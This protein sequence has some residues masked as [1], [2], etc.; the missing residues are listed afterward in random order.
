MRMTVP[1]QVT[2][3]KLTV[4]IHFG[5]L[6][7]YLYWASQKKTDSLFNLFQ[8]LN[9]GL[10]LSETFSF[11]C[12][13]KAINIQ[14]TEVQRTYTNTLEALVARLFYNPGMFINAPHRLMLTVASHA[15]SPSHATTP[16]HC[17]YYQRTDMLSADR[18][19][20]CVLRYYLQTASAAF[21]A[22]TIV[23]QTYTSAD[24]SPAGGSGIVILRHLTALGGT[25]SLAHQKATC[26]NYLSVQLTIRV[27]LDNSSHRPHYT[28]E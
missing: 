15:A 23:Q 16:W 5:I 25:V 4:L 27:L 1:F 6:P 17:C 26:G 9:L 2:L 7:E 19:I 28:I 10:W 14:K 21:R 18:H 11:K 12:N 13:R 22:V 24:C 20:I 3:N 8:E